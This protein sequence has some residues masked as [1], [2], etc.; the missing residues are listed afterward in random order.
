LPALQKA[1]LDKPYRQQQI[2]QF[3]ALHESIRADASATAARAIHA[4]V[5]GQQ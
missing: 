4:L 1:L 3:Y 5:A 2:A